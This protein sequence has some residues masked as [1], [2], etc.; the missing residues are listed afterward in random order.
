MFFFHRSRSRFW[1][2]F[3][4]FLWLI[5]R[6]EKGTEI[7]EGITPDWRRFFNNCCKKS[8][9]SW[10][11]LRSWERGTGVRVGT[12]RPAGFTAGFTTGF[13]SGFTTGFIDSGL[14]SGLG[15]GFDSGFDSV[16]RWRRGKEEGREGEEEGL[17]EGGGEEMEGEGEEGLWEGGG[18]GMEGGREGDCSIL[19]ISTSTYERISKTCEFTYRSNFLFTFQ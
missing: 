12:I 16:T 3:T 5:N 7:S 18:Q 2:W 8:P 13:N 9:S 17:W 15:S 6:I 4:I 14:G 1:F 10:S 19:L 11:N